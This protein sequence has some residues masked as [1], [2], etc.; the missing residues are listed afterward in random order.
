M[1]MG[2]ELKKEAVR[3]YLH[4]FRF[5]FLAVLLLFVTTVAV[6]VSYAVRNNTPRGND[7]APTERVYDYADVLT[8]EEE[9]SLRQY[10]AQKEAE[11]KIDFVIMTFSQ[12]VSGQEAKEQYGYASADWERNMRDIADDF[13]DE[14]GYGYNKSFE[15]DGSILIDNRYEGDRGEWLS[16]S[17]SV[18]QN[19]GTRAVDNVLYAVDAY[20]DSNP[21][22]AY[23]AYIDAVCSYMGGGRHIDVRNSLLY[24]VLAALIVSIVYAGVHVSR[25]KAQ[26]T[27]RANTYVPGGKPFLREKRDDFIRKH[28]VTHRIE[29]DNR[30]GGGPGGGGGGGHHMSSGGASHGGGGHRH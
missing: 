23:K 14:N 7:Q 27:V 30:G 1:E 24:A 22:R 2:N 5:W 26:K 11:Y 3:Q 29:R 16:T 12:P 10:I 15:G 25:N 19:L 9:S 4:Y 21:Y 17:G 13:W 18:E 28:V 20:Y 8:D 6:G